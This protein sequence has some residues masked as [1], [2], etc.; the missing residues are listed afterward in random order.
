MQ[1]HPTAPLLVAFSKA[2]DIPMDV[3]QYVIANPDKASEVSA[4]IQARFDTLGIQHSPY[5]VDDLLRGAS[6]RMIRALKEAPFECVDELMICKASQFKTLPNISV[7]SVETVSTQLSKAGYGFMSEQDVLLDRLTVL[8]LDPLL[9]PVSALHMHELR[10]LKEMKRFYR[11][12]GVKRIRDLIAIP[13]QEL[14]DL[15][16]AER[17]G[18]PMITIPTT[19]VIGTIRTKLADLQLELEAA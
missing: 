17:I 9:A 6:P 18:S 2:L 8:Y 13:E 3:M 15:W 19:Q 14:Q 4:L 1:I 12:I 16:R 5:W 10:R 11:A 7:T